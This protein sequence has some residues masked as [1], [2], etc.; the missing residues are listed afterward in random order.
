MEN[1]ELLRRYIKNSPDSIL[2]PSSGRYCLYVSHSCPFAHRT[3]IARQLKGLEDAIEMIELDPVLP[4]SGIGWHFSEKYSDTLNGWKR[5]KQGYDLTFGC[6][7]TGNESEP[8]LW[9]KKTRSFINNE[10]LDIMRMILD[11]FNDVALNPDLD[12]RPQSNVEQIEAF[13]HYLNDNFSDLIYSAHLS[14]DPV[15]KSK[16]INTVFKVAEELEDRLSINRFLHGKSLTESDLVLFPTLTRFEAVYEPL[17]KINQKKLTDYPS[18][19]KYMRDMAQ[20]F[21]L[22]NTVRFDINVKSYYDSPMLNPDGIEAPVTPVPNL[23]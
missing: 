23:D 7:Y 17:F 2:P 10:S 20:T 14:S 18:M 6:S 4:A 16:H 13:T 22:C 8:V 3:I 12:L 5:L 1:N 19:V 21:S 15:A 11:E 9:D